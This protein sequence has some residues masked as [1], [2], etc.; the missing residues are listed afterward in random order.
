[1][2]EL[3][4]RAERRCVCESPPDKLGGPLQSKKHTGREASQSQTD[5]HSTHPCW[6]PALNHQGRSNDEAE[7]LVFGGGWLETITF[8]CFG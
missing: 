6:P 3:D 5:A 2:V 1:M 4:P 8:E 7:D